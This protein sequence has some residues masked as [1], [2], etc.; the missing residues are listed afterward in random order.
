M[1]YQ[2]GKT[3]A[4]YFIQAFAIIIVAHWIQK[5]MGRINVREIL[6]LAA[7]GAATYFVLDIFAPSVGNAARVGA[8]FGIGL[9]QVGVGYSPLMAPVNMI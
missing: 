4:K 7:I 6:L 5:G 9:N 3:I 8:G 2:L 1:D